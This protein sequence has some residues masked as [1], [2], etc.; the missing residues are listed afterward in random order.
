[1]SGLVTR[2]AGIVGRGRARLKSLGSAG[3][4]AFAVVGLIVAIFLADGFRVTT[5]D[6]QVPGVWVTRREGSL[7]GRFNTQALE[8][9][10]AVPTE[11]ADLDVAQDGERVAV[12][13]GDVLKLVDPATEEVSEES[14][15]MPDGGGRV[16]LA[17][18]RYLI[19]GNDGNAWTGSG[20]DVGNWDEGRKPDLQAS[21]PDLVA[22]GPD[23]TVAAFDAD[24]GRAVVIDSNGERRT[25]EFSGVDDP[26]ALQLS[27]A[28]TT[29][30]VLD[31][32][33]GRLLLP[34][35][36]PVDLTNF[37]TG[38]QLQLRSDDPD[39]VYVAT[40]GG[41]VTIPVGGGEPKV[42]AED[43]VDAAVRPV[44]ANGCTYAAWTV[45]SYMS[46]RCSDG[47]HAEKQLEHV[48]G[49]SADVRFRVN[50]SNV[51][52]ND[53]QTG[54]V[55]VRVGDR[56]EEKKGEWKVPEQEDPDDEDDS[57]PVVKSLDIEQEPKPP[58]AEDDKSGARRNRSTIVS[59]LDN[60]SDPNGDVITIDPADLQVPPTLNVSV[61]SQG[62]AL[63]VTP[64][65]GAASTVRFTYR[66]TDGTRL[67]SEP[68]TVTVSVYGDDVNTAPRP[69][70]DLEQRWFSV[71]I[72]TPGSYE[73]LPDWEDPE[74]DPIVLAGATSDVAVGEVQTVPTGRLTYKATAGAPGKRT[75]EV[76]VADV[77]PLGAQSER[78]S[79]TLSVEVLGQ[80]Q[81]LGPRPEPD[82]AVGSVGS[83]ITVFPLRNDI[84]PNGDPLLITKLILPESKGD[85]PRPSVTLSP[86]DGKVVVRSD[87][88][89][90]FVFGYEVTDRV[91][92]AQA[93]IRV[94]VVDPQQNRPP[95]AGPDLVL[96]PPDQKPRTLDL[97]VN[98]WD[99]DGDVLMVSGLRQLS[100]PP[101][102][103]QL[104]EHRRARV[105]ADVPMN[106]PATFEYTVSDG[107]AQAT[108]RLTV[109]QSPI[110]AGNARPVIGADTATVRTGDVISI[111]V[112]LNDVDPE[113]DVLTLAPEL[114]RGPEQGQGTA[115]VS[116]S[117]VRFVAPNT[118][119]TVR[120]AYGVSDD[121]RNWSSGQV[122]ITVRSEQAGV[123]PLP[124]TIE[125]RVLAGNAT[126]VVIP[127]AG[128]DPDGDSVGLVGVGPE[129][130]PRL[131]RVVT[132]VGTDSI[133]YE[134]FASDAGG[135]DEF[136]YQV[137][138]SRGNTATG[139]VRVVVAPRTTSSPPQPADDE[140]TI[141]PGEVAVVP[142]LDND[143]DP[144]G[145]A[146]QLADPALG[147]LPEGLQ[148]E[149]E[150]GSSRIRV[151]APGEPG[152]VAP[153]LYFV[154]DGAGSQ[155]VFGSIKV[156]VDPDAP[157]QPPVARD[158]VARVTD[159][160]AESIS[161]DVRANDE[162]PDGDR[163]ELNVEVISPP[164]AT[165]D[166]GQVVVA[167]GPSPQVV[168]YRVTD[169]QGLSAAAVVRVPAMGDLADLP[170]EVIKDAPVV[171][172]KGGETTVIDV[173]DRVVDPEGQP[174][175]LT[176]GNLV[177]AT[178]GVATVSPDRPGEITYTA[179]AAA[180]GAA[181][182]MFEV[183][184]SPDVNLGNKVT[185]SV[186]ITVVPGDGAAVPLKVLPGNPVRIGPGDDPVTIDLAGRIDPSSATPDDVD[187]SLVDPG[188]TGLS[189]D[190]DG[191]RV[192]L[193][194]S[195]GVTV[196]DVV[197][198]AF[199]A[200]D[201]DRTAD[202]TVEVQ[203]VESSKPPVSCTVQDVTDAAAGEQLTVNVLNNCTNPFPD[204]DLEL[205]SASDDGGAGARVDG[206]SVVLTP[207]EGFVGTITVGYEVSDKVGRVTTGVL[208]VIVR[209]VPGAPG[210]PTVVDEASRQ[211]VLSWTAPD[212]HGA[213]IT[214]YLVS[215][216]SLSAP[217]DCGT[218]TTCTVT[219][220]TNDVEYRFSVTA[221]N[222]VGEGPAGP[223]ATA[224]PDQRP[225]PPASVSLEFSK[226]HIDG[227]LV[228]SWSAARTEG[229]AVTGYELEV[230][231]PP[232][233]GPAR[234]Q[235][236][237][238][239]EHVIEG[240]KNGTA[241]RVRVRAM[242][243]AATGASDWSADS[244]AETPATVPGAPSTPTVQTVNDPLGE[245]VEVRWTPG[246]E[247]G[248]TITAYTLTAF[249]A[250]TD[251]VH[252]TIALPGNQAMPYVLDLDNTSDKFQIQVVATN[253]A[254]DSLPSGR[255]AQVQA[256]RAPDPVGGITVTPDDGGGVNGLDRRLAL[257]FARPATGGI[258]ITRYLVTTSGQTDRQFNVQPSDTQPRLV[259]DGLN[260]GTEYRFT[261]KA[262]NASYCSAASAQSG[263][264][265][266]YG[267]VGQ[268]RLSVAGISQTQVNF[269]IDAPAATNGRPIDH[270][271]VV[272]GERIDAGGG[273]V[274]RGN[275]CGQTHSI[276]VVAYDSE[277][278]QSAAAS[279]SA[280]TTCPPPPAVSASWGSP[281]SVAGCTSNCYRMVATVSSFPANG[282]FGVQC[283]FRT[284]STAAWRS[285]FG[286]TPPNIV[287]DG[288]GNGS[289]GNTA[290]SC[291][292]SPSGAWEYRFVINGVASN[293]I[294]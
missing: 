200:K 99:P 43:D 51:A 80:G 257:T 274:L 18:D 108:G 72:G 215:A 213:P 204:V 62:Q 97:L 33:S 49:S 93:W 70:P 218:L 169:P 48:T 252:K 39:H 42:A 144:D 159:K 83:N 60:D 171:E 117:S 122:L 183:T 126:R 75:L 147:S 1:V 166:A 197:S 11:I 103:V 288:A 17:G 188:V 21:A 202:G 163:D 243:K 58:V 276:T 209:D 264:G 172:V 220:L 177:S 236:G 207:A 77:P 205:V 208:R 186:P 260:N 232:A 68:A 249:Q 32:A 223:S 141:A 59:V 35:A 98:D 3:F 155:P 203:I 84:D 231:P 222:E 91:E 61:V 283:Q 109:A 112:L 53:L 210:A 199:T 293:P 238:V 14:L 128:I 255:S 214:K 286:Y 224:R 140:V 174:L 46:V 265:T 256:P 29:P 181:S 227:K 89:E 13:Q 101:V 71:Q 85:A 105:W 237:A 192:T 86:D 30:V 235:L 113:G 272:G 36:E 242:N 148:A 124:Q 292:G 294:G 55:A 263:P 239:T 125:A 82:Y 110:A 180:F 267:P 142:V 69:K 230:V 57:D 19:V 254:G 251:S 79:G 118:P 16:E 76:Q 90:P 5:Y 261:V 152:P 201:G 285:D 41:V 185:V 167:P 150:G 193:T 233:T 211:V 121:G 275:A 229:S 34:D 88:A 7:V 258:D 175:Q 116:G 156:T 268:P 170:P 176:Q 123:P 23:G 278:Q 160:S 284:S 135:R 56:V 277:G 280:S 120:L 66:A 149:V 191:S 217:F 262:C 195:E 182:V 273:N 187:F 198:V 31:G 45:P 133:T 67:K 248:S 241:Y 54:A 74:G 132:P 37:G 137:R 271:Q 228:A 253:K 154:T 107:A 9:D 221:V 162:D 194:A 20:G 161:V 95:S 102:A 15:E 164:G 50:R 153:L 245:K 47:T 87:T 212:A 115:F 151:T 24:S 234:I 73:V 40:P 106:E 287:T 114:Q 119:G 157:G 44:R 129:P 225:D 270:L 10:S 127:L 22:I 2:A 94:D 131:G 134:A 96:L 104:L 165:V 139:R 136:A 247:N 92:T 269:R 78:G 12:F 52:L 244:N 291:V 64:T 111:P 4:V 219:G 289:T 196:G 290:A 28:G 259:V 130:A 279:V 27:L 190:P 240:L 25:I 138:D 184:D 26:T 282:S 81:N 189:V 168:V 179:D 100:G 38:L 216:P 63:Q 143:F 146:I 173:A 281:T 6:L 178:K 226:D 250:G 266:P 8:I 65:D 145:D 206:S 246:A 158:D